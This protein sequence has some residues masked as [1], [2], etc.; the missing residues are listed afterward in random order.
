[1]LIFI[2][3]A[4]MIPMSSSTPIMLGRKTFLILYSGDLSEK[5][6]PDFSLQEFSI[7]PSNAVTGMPKITRKQKTMH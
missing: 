5:K 4:E 1:M 2:L 3:F 7:T 6:H